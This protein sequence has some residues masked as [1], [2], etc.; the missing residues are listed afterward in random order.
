MLRPELLQP[1]P[2]DTARVARAA[3]RK[4]NLY[5]RLRDELGP[6]YS[7]ET[8]ALLFSSTGRPALPP[9][10]LALVTVVQ[11]LEGLS[12][13]QAADAVRARIDLKYLLGLELTDPGFD[14][15]VLCEFRARL[16]AHQVEAQLF[17]VL[18]QRFQQRGLLRPRGVQRTDSTHVLAAVR[19]IS[20]LALLGETLRAALNELAVHDPAWLA[21]LLSDVWV[22]RYARRIEESRLP[23]SD[24][25]RERHALTI[26]ADGLQLLEALDASGSSEL[27]ALPQVV[28]LRRVW[29]QQF[30]V[31]SETGELRWRAVDDLPAASE[32]VAS[33]YDV[34]AHFATKRNHTWLGYKVHLSETCDAD[35]PEL[36]THVAVTSAPER[37]IVAVPDI[38]EA[39]QAKGLLPSRHLMDAGYI[40]A[41]ILTS[42]R[43]ALGIEVVGP[44]KRKT[45]WQERTE[46]AFTLADFRIDWERHDVM[47]PQNFLNQSWTEFKDRDG[48]PLVRVQ[49]RRQTCERCP[50]RE[51]C[52]RSDPTKTGRTLTFRRREQHEALQAS[53][54]WEDSAAW[55]GVYGLREGIEGTVSQ[56]VRRFD[57]R[58]ARYWGEAKVRLQ[59]LG[60]AAALNLVRFD[61]WLLGTPRSTTR[62]ARF[63]RLSL[64]A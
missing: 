41:E 6:L 3:F 10:R 56:A 21:P 28:T 48:T 13:R 34:E 5:L 51:R 27:Q 60:T 62:K 40:S 32:R 11:F 58:Q 63:A 22:E 2:A 52:T 31:S 35:L 26:G 43:K 18:L 16:L 8:F 20:R 36:V 33:P 25:G 38:H 39:L 7:D 49:F 64:S 42:T 44:V 59:A 61:A 45:S 9:W 55:S 47:C 23:R 19:R 30:E 12:D 29:A 1:I 53:R 14:F 4:G 24:A 37:D 57:L 50:V 46:G 54:A 15:S 17:D